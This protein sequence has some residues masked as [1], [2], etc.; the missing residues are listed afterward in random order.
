MAAFEH[1]TTL[2]AF[3][4]A[5]AIAHVLS[6]LIALIRAGS[7][8][9]YSFAHGAW[10]LSALYTVYTWWLAMY[11]FHSLRRWD[12]LSITIWLIGA[13]FVYMYSGLVSP[14]VPSEGLVDLDQFHFAHGRQ[15]QAALVA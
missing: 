14:E 9:R 4:F 8:V 12:V 6:T 5:L 3:V 15:Y 2:I 13:V 7:R 10:F 1:V 11:D